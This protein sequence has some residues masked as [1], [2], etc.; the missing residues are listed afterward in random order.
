MKRRG[1]WIPSEEIYSV[2]LYIIKVPSWFLGKRP[3]CGEV[4]KPTFQC[5][6]HKYFFPVKEIGHK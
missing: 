3:S 2:G 1:D 5:R 4:P 6:K